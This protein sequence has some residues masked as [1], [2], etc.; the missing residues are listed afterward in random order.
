[1]LYLA[2]QS[3]RRQSILKDLQVHF[4]LLLPSAQEDA[5]S[6]ENLIDQEASLDY[7]RRVTLAK[8][9]AAHTRLKSR[10][11][12][13][14]P[15]LCADTTV[16]IQLLEKEHI[17]GKP[18]NNSDAIHML[19]LLSGKVHQVHTAVAVLGAPNKLPELLVSSSEVFFAPLSE[20]TIQ[21]Y[22]ETKEPMGKAGAYGIQ[23]LGSCLIEKIH[24][25]YSGI[26]G[27]PIFE[28][29][30]LLEKASIPYILSL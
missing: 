23:G 5:E 4:E 20:Q 14:A 3:P 26:M 9:E 24:G 27:L 30:Q 8:L 16:A 13:F 19:T 28:T 2:S 25:S 12:P 21:A 29:C 17:L 7:V 1:M 6:L 18:L 10:G 22:V 11:L 15:I